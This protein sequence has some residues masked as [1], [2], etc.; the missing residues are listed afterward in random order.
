MVRD[1][2]VETP[3]DLSGG[4]SITSDDGTQES[5][6]G[7]HQGHPIDYLEGSEV[8]VCDEHLLLEALPPRLTRVQKRNRSGE[9]IS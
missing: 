3:L 1:G 6:I 2:T 5:F 4:D 7:A 9:M 8:Q